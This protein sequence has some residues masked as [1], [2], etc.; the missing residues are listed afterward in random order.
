MADAPAIAYFSIKN[1]ALSAATLPREL[2]L[3]RFGDN[4]TDQGT[5]KVTQ[6]TL[7]ALNG[8]IAKGVFERVLIDF[9]HNSLEG[10]PKYQPPPRKHAGVGVLAASADGGIMLKDVTWTPDG[11]QYARGYPDI[12]P[13]VPYD[14]TTMEILGLSSVGLVPNGSVIGLSFFSA[15]YN[16]EEGSTQ[17]QET[18]MELAALKQQVD[19]LAESV[20]ALMTKIDGLG[21]S[22]MTAKVTELETALKPLAT[23]KADIDAGFAKRDKDA[24]LV[25]AAF[26]GKVP[27]LT[28]EAIAKL[29]VEDLRAH[30]E[31]LPVTVPLHLRTAHFAAKPPEGGEGSPIAQFNAISDPGKRA[32]FY[33]KNKDKLVG[34]S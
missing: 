2:K 31:K 5:F 33:A 4:P 28:D 24:L 21:V 14:K 7:D 32:E 17:Q 34:A 23:L 13:V 18:D 11:E 26:A 3:F 12:S 1:H 22:A 16:P 8:Q 10:S 27:T 20:T 30:I 9:E 19:K 15:L 29:S 6:R 25:Q